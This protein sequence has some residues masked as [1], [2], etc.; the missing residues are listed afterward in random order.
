MLSLFIW[1]IFIC[2]GKWQADEWRSVKVDR[3]GWTEF[4]RGYCIRRVIFN[5]LLNI[6]RWH[7]L[8]ILG[9]VPR[10]WINLDSL[11]WKYWKFHRYNLHRPNCRAFNHTLVWAHKAS[12]KDST[13]RTRIFVEPANV[14]Q[15]HQAMK[16]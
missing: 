12:N 2:L 13:E 10:S 14:W 15:V 3:S 4:Y 8:L 16:Y 1:N 9:N 7:F 11:Y 5:S 6:F